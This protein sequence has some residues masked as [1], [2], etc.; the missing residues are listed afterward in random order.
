MH[1]H[2]T[3]NEAAKSIFRAPLALVQFK[4]HERPSLAGRQAGA[5]RRVAI[6]PS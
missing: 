2:E 4:A 1:T 6:A 5:E 3:D